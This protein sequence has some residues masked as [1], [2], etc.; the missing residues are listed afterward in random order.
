MMP[1]GATT[2]SARDT[3]TSIESG[4]DR[5]GPKPLDGVRVLEV[6]AW[7]MVPGAGV[8][9]SDLGAEV[10]KVEHPR[11]GDPARGLVTGG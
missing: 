3:D 5:P 4:E 11:A 9:L 2:M 10:I 7:V 8:L 1:E 6:S